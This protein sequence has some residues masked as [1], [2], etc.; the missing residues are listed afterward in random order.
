MPFML[1]IICNRNEIPQG[2]TPFQS[3]DMLEELFDYYGNQEEVIDG[4]LTMIVMVMDNE[5]NYYV[6]YMPPELYTVMDELKR[7]GVEFRYS[8]MFCG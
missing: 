3:G 4:Q 8:H 7:H 6:D 5:G 2:I 1:R